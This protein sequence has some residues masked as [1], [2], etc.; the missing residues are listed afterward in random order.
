MNAFTIK[1]LENLSGIKAH[2]IRIWEQRYN[3][4]KPQRTDTNIRY[5]SSDELKTVLNIALLNKYG[6]KISHIDRMQPEE[7]KAKILSLGDAKAIQERIVN[8]LVQ[9]MVDLN[10]EKLEKILAN[11][12]SLR[13]I[14]KTVIHIIFPFLEKIGLLWVTGHINPAQ[15]HLVTNVI[16]QKL[17]VAIETAITH[18][19]VDKTVL[20]FLPEGEHHE[21]GLLFMYYMLKNRGIQTIYLGANVPVKDVAYVARLKKPDIV[22][23]HLTATSSS[24][25]FEKFLNS[26]NSQF[27]DIQTVISG[28]LTHS[29]TKNIPNGIKFKKSL[30]EV[31]EYLTSL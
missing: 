10:I 26:I 4:L 20:L 21:L 23:T 31:M 2:T 18:L 7:I 9:E 22:F 30:Q 25:N 5:Y 8:E 6:F 29:Y 15:E 3:F 28:Q 17:I 27:N 19:K 16:R 11:Y 12:I 1:D 13:G 14:E 24:F